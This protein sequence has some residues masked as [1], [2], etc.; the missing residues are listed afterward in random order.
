MRT[1]SVLAALAFL[2]LA[3]P[4]RGDEKTDPG[5]LTVERI[6][7]AR[8]FVGDLFSA[9]WVKGIDGYLTWEPS[10]DPAGGKDLVRH[11]PAKGETWV[12]VSSARLV[13]PGGSR[14]LNVE[15]YAFSKGCNRFG[16][17]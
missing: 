8:E 15:E 7:A 14:P 2:F 9:R 11:D 10:S 6:F 3:I 16:Y 17:K 12:L 13:P 4:S 5:R 1:S